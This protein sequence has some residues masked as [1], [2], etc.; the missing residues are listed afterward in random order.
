MD[1]VYMIHEIIF[2]CLPFD[3]KQ[4]HQSINDDHLYSPI[5]VHTDEDAF[6]ELYLD[7]HWKHVLCFPYPQRRWNVDNS[8][9]YLHH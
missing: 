8:N 4:Q 5:K 3:S 9:V 1:I 2:F 6:F 7:S